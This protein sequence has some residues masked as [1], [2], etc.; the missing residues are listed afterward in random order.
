MLIG[1]NLGEK[2]KIEGVVTD[3]I[4]LGELIRY[5]VLIDNK[6]EI[7]AKQPTVSLQSAFCAGTTV[8]LGWEDANAMIL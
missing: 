8:Q 5:I 3:V 1:I 2:K 4:Y 7:V 6:Y